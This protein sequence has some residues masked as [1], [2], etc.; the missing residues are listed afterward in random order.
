MHIGFIRSDADH[1]LYF[2]QEGEHVMI[3]IIY[4]DD[5]IILANYMSS[6]KV[7]K[8]M[9][10]KEYEMTDLDELYFCLGVE[11]VRDKVARTITM[12]QGKYIRDVLKRFAMDDCKAIGTPLDVNSKLLKLMD[13]EYATEA[14]SMVEVPYKQAVGSL[15]YAMIGTR[16]DLAFPISVVSQHMA[17][18]GSKHLVAVKRIIEVK[19]LSKGLK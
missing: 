9:L 11:F 7:L 3:V 19:K 15:M 6:M 14:Q 1:S 17:K 4:V 13:E 12:C 10:E 5:L 2:M 8:A 18:P 16:P